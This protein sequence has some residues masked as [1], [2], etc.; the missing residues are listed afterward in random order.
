ME[1][2]FFLLLLLLSISASPFSIIQQS[3]SRL[4]NVH[5]VHSTIRLKY[6][7]LSRE[8]SSHEGGL[9]KLVSMRDGFVACA[10]ANIILV[11]H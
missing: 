9:E 2:L 3:R 11:H 4:L 6:I 8:R 10:G 5:H 1:A 7:I